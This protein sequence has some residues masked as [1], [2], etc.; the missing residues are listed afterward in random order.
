MPKPLLGLAAAKAE[1]GRATAAAPLAEALLNVTDDEL[2]SKLVSLLGVTGVDA[3]LLPYAQRLAVGFFSSEVSAAER[4]LAQRSARMRRGTPSAHMRSGAPAC[5]A[6]HPLAQ[7]SARLAQRSA[8]L[9]SGAPAC[10]GARPL[11]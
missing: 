5:A 6:D 3:M 4:L 11:A 7:R 2:G 1:K 10:V 8:R 9:R